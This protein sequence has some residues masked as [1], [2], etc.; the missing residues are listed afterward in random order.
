MALFLVS[1]PIEEPLPAFMQ[2]GF[3]Q[4]PDMERVDSAYSDK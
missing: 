4:V 2:G 1:Q 3:V